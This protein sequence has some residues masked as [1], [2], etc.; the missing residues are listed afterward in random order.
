MA[1][2][3]DRIARALRSPQARRLAD[4]AA[5]VARD[6]ATRRRIEEFRNRL[7]RKR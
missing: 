4:K 1:S 7:T 6:P 5:E 2:L 3:T